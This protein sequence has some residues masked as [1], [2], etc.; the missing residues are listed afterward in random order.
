MIASL[1][2]DTGIAPSALL[3][4]SDEMLTTL[5]MVLQQRSKHR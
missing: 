4:E 3:T 1:A 2:I 5:F